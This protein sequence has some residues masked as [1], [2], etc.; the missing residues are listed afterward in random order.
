V[1]SVSRSA[2]A[3]ARRGRHVILAAIAAAAILG[4][5][6]A[7]SAFAVIVH[8]GAGHYVSYQPTLAGAQH[9]RSLARRGAPLRSATTYKPCSG[10]EPACLTYYGGPVMLTTT[11]TPVFWNPSGLGLGY[12]AGYE[13]EIEQFI[14]GLAAESGG[15]GNFFSVLP[16]YYEQSGG[17]KHV[18]YQVTAGEPQLDAKALPTGAGEQCTDPFPSSPSPRKCVTDLGVTNEL[19]SLI[20][21]R[22]LPTGIGHEYVVF[23]PEGMDS[24]FDAAGTECSGNSYCG[25]HST[26]LSIYGSQE[27]QYANEPDNADAAFNKG[28]MA[29]EGVTAAYATVDT[30]SHEVSE[31]VTDPE[32]NVVGKLGWYD[33][34][35]A[36]GQEYG[37][38]GDMCAWE[39][40]QGDAAGSGPEAVEG[41]NQM[42]DGHPYL[43]Q[44]EWDNAHSTCSISEE[45]AGTRARFNDSGTPAAKLGDSVLFDAEESHSPVAITSYE[46]NWGDGTTTV[47]S[48]PNTTH[49]YTDIAGLPA[50]DF[51]VTLTVT[52]ANGNTDTATKTIE[53]EDQ[54][55]VAAFAAP[56]SVNAASPAQFE[57]T[58]SGDP[59][60][61]A[62]SYSWSFG[63]GTT[64]SGATPSHVY[65][66]PG[67]YT[68][69]L[70][71]T[72]V[73]GKTATISHQ[74]TVND[75]PPT[76]SFMLSNGSPVA[77]QSVTFNGSG[78][79]DVDGSALTETWSFGDGTA[80]TG[81]QAQH[82]YAKAGA[83]TVKLTVT[84]SA[85]LSA[86]TEQTVTVA[87][88]PNAFRVVGVSRNRRRGTVTLSVAV[89]WSGVLSAQDAGGAHASGFL[90]GLIRALSFQFA[91]EGRRHGKGAPRSAVVVKSASTD[92][93]GADTVKLVIAPTRA[94]L[95][96][97]AQGHTLPVKLTITFT[98]IDGEAKSQPFTIKLFKQ[99]TG[100]KGKAGAH[101]KRG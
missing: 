63:D 42:I 38:I 74:I 44:T 91:R 53:V 48:A 86:T 78:S 28:C 49:T 61:A 34:E 99:L 9:A 57:A 70:T 85:G 71:V 43:L 55:P 19:R 62:V 52:D 93:S 90:T 98:P 30:T 73:A 26:L 16:Q 77:G 20:E 24:C 6:G 31:S 82:A 76:A 1:E 83:Y 92:A 12:E 80:A 23:F 94:G 22:K 2:A 60:G 33:K 67:V 79:A 35:E 11:L 64:G 88:P 89:P 36:G 68:V 40:K 17:I 50:K 37:E 5:L 58:G 39:F 69:T 29:E 47:S 101:R 59:D 75:T 84:D 46:W 10:G 14:D 15:E 65:A 96:K 95:R 100:R 13:A 4:A 25:Y 18:A 97:L 54:P 32:V 51:T 7:S 21:T 27:V 8:T 81:A 66:K 41:P 45:A 3:V 87:A 56:G 72:D